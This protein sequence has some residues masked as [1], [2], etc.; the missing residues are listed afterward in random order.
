MLSNDDFPDVRG[1]ASM[2]LEWLRGHADWVAAFY[3]SEAR[4]DERLFRHVLLIALNHESSEIRCE[5]LNVLQ[6]SLEKHDTAHIFARPI[7]ENLARFQGE[8]LLVALN[9]I[10]LSC[11]PSLAEYLVPF[12]GCD[13]PHV[14]IEAFEANAEL[15][16]VRR[17][18]RP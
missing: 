16:S 15:E 8:E 10:G 6:R 7:A 18:N 12:L 11:D 1:G 2:I 4:G 3:P 13:D 9:I 17:H 14:R 5:A